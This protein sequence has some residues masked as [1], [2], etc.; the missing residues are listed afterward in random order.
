MYKYLMWKNEIVIAKNLELNKIEESNTDLFPVYIKDKLNFYRDFS[1]KDSINHPIKK[2]EEVFEDYIELRN[3]I[4][5]G[6]EEMYQSMLD[7][8]WIKTSDDGEVDW[9]D[10]SVRNKDRI[11]DRNREW[12]NKGNGKFELWEEISDISNAKNVIEIMKM[13]MDYGK[14]LSIPKICDNFIV[15]E[16]TL[17]DNEIVLACEF[18]SE[19]YSAFDRLS[20]FIDCDLIF[21]IF[22]NADSSCAVSYMN[23]FDYLVA[24]PTRSDFD[25]GFVIDCC[26]NFEENR[27]LNEI[28]IVYYAYLEN[29]FKNL[30]EFFRNRLSIK[31]NFSKTRTFNEIAVN[32]AEYVDEN[33]NVFKMDFENENISKAFKLF[34]YNDLDLFDKYL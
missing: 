28:L 4:S 8:Y 16:L 25:Y 34:C 15:S 17:K 14:L 26:E 5:L 31:C 24:N 19:N 9:N 22:E 21:S 32:D 33:K 2:I 10:I 23:V 18:D 12:K 3:R 11:V 1:K 29:S 13:S 20:E 27:Q 30:D 7:F 6:K